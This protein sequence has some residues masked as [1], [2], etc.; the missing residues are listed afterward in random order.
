MDIEQ[1]KSTWRQMG[2][3]IDNLER[4]NRRMAERLAAGKATTAQ[5]RLAKTALRGVFCGLLLPIL[6]PLLYYY[7]GFQPWIAALYGF[8]GIVMSVANILFYKS[9]VKCD[10]MSLP[11]VNAMMNA[12][13]IRSNL[14]NIRILG[15]S[16]GFGII[17][18][19]IFDTIE[20]YEMSILTGMIIGFICG[21][22]IGLKKWREQ[23]ALSKAIIQE[24]RAAM[25]EPYSE[26]DIPAGTDFK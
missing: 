2:Q 23:S 17:F 22:I 15:I 4:E 6:A 14:R 21:L 8:F 3:R 1:L 13:R 10:Y 9:I 25:Q 19:L 11:L 5:R 16:M 7:L 12:V 26:S 20:R 18:S 24:L